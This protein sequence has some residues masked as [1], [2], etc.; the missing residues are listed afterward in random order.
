MF[1]FTYMYGYIAV[2]YYC[3]LV[4]IGVMI[5]LNLFLAILLDNFEPEEEAAQGGQQNNS[6]MMAVNNGGKDMSEALSQQIS[7]R[8]NNATLRFRDQL[9]DYFSKLNCFQRV[10]SNPAAGDAPESSQRQGLN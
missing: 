6:Q 5:F 7:I 3:S 1:E 9:R 2:A 8:I 4:I 10:S